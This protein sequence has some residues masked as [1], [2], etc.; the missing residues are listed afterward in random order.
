MESG[1]I[2]VAEH[3]GV[4]AIKLVGDVR[5]TLCCEFYDYVQ[6]LIA[7]QSYVDCVIDLSQSDNLDSTTLGVLA[8]VAAS[9]IK[10]KR[11][12]PTIY[13]PDESIYR[14]LASM[15]FDK[16][17]NLCT[18]CIS[19]EDAFCELNSA[20]CADEEMRVKVIEAHKVLMAMSD[21]NKATFSPLVEAL[22]S[23]RMSAG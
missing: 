7:D 22:E 3:S 17:F 9:A 5:V 1:K 10:S 23:E 2:L 8:K 6:T 20:T 12:K 13:A 15:S 18:D 16:V 4:H 21:S 11:V 19:G 14:L